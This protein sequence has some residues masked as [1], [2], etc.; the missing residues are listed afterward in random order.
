MPT[1]GVIVVEL[2]P[3]R[4]RGRY[5]AFRSVIWG[6]SWGLSSWASGSVLGRLIRF[7]FGRR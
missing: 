6:M 5:L 3:E 2:A 7:C 1:S 4:L